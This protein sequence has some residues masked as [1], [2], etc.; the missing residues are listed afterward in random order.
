[1]FNPFGKPTQ[2]EATKSFEVKD[3]A[4]ALDIDL[5]VS[6]VNLRRAKGID[7]ATVQIELLSKDG[8]VEQF[9]MKALKFISLINSAEIFVDDYAKKLTPSEKPKKYFGEHEKSFIA[10]AMPKALE[11]VLV[12]PNN[13]LFASQ[14][15]G[16]GA[17]ASAAAASAAPVSNYSVS[18][19]WIDPG[20][21]VCDA[22]ETIF[23]EVFEVK[24]DTCIIKPGAPLNDGLRIQEA[25]EACPVEVIKFTKVA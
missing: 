24:A 9:P 7:K 15:V 8:L 22:C 19:V 23:P 4:F 5:G 2:I 25:A 11:R 16:A 1:L 14:F 20:C 10:E 13:P 17:G 3:Q 21:I 6:Y 18:K 12:L